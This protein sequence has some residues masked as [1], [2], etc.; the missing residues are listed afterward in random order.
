MMRRTGGQLGRAF[1]GAGAE[2]REV[3][4]TRRRVLEALINI[5]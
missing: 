2:E 5:Y 1:K 4:L 3:V